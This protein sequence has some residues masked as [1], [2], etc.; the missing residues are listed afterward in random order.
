MNIYDGAAREILL[1][2][3]IESISVDELYGEWKVWAG[4]PANAGFL[5]A[6]RTFGGDP[7]IAGQ[8]APAYFF[9]TNG[10]RCIVDGFEVVVGTNLYTDEGDSALIFRNGG[11]GNVK[12]SDSPTVYPEQQDVTVDLDAI[13]NAVAA[14]FAF[15]GDKVAAQIETVPTITQELGLNSV[16]AQ[17][18]NDLWQLEGLDPNQ[19]MNVSPIRRSAGSGLVLQIVREGDDVT[20]YRE[21]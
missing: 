19:P 20:V 3:S 4:I 13:A 14:K 17:Q 2:P 11:V 1:D 21:S 15:V 12:N 18:L 16:Q 9:L 6:F 10:W 7:L 5:P 8:N